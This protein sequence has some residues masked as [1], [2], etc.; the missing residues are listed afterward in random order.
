MGEPVT[1]DGDFPTG[2]GMEFFTV[3]SEGAVELLVTP[4]SRFGTAT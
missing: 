3:G 1:S 2:R 4:A